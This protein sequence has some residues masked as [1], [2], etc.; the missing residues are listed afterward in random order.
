MTALRMPTQP[1]TL[2]HRAP[3]KP[4]P[5]FSPRVCLDPPVPP[6][7]PL[8]VRALMKSC[9]DWQQSKKS[10][11]TCRSASPLR[12]NAPRCLIATGSSLLMRKPSSRH[13]RTLRAPWDV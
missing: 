9:A 2:F 10:C 8:Q 1:D 12:S 7:R 11:M 3:L 6:P 13:A 4:P 5:P